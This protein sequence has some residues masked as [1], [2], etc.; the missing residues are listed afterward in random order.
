ME[1][2][3]KLKRRPFSA[4]TVNDHFTRKLIIQTQQGMQIYN[5]KCPDITKWQRV[6]LKVK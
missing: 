1:H 3:V 5:Q 4:F 2:S 6:V